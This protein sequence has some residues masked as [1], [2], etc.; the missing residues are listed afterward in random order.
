MHCAC[1]IA[2]RRS[3][4]AR[5]A[6]SIFACC[7]RICGAMLGLDDGA[8]PNRIYR[9]KGNYWRLNLAK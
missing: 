6:S 5:A 4:R 7:R 2:G 1:R 9:K 8:M 3:R